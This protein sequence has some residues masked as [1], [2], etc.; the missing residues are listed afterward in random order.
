MNELYTIRLDDL[1]TLIWIRSYGLYIVRSNG[2]G[3]ALEYICPLYLFRKD[4][5]VVNSHLV[6]VEW[7]IWVVVQGLIHHKSSFSCILAIWLI[8]D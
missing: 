7:W 2:L 6:R 5:F 4:I 8:F 3:Y 1:H